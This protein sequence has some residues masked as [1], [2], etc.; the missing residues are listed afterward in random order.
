MT[1]EHD[2]KKKED[3]LRGRKEQ[4]VEPDKEKTQAPF[5]TKQ[6]KNRSFCQSY[7]LVNVTILCQARCLLVLLICPT[8][9]WANKWPNKLVG[10]E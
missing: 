3:E 7:V 1:K 8:V 9:R 5:E 2:L 6:I 4:D 10:N